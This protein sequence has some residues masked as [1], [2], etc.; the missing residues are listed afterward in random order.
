MTVEVRT[1]EEKVFEVP[2]LFVKNVSSVLKFLLGCHH[3]G[4]WHQPKSNSQFRFSI[5]SH[6]ETKEETKTKQLL[7]HHYCS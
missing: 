2:P 1:P 3:H 7:L 4:F 6:I 5:Q